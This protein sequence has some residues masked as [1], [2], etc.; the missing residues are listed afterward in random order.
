MAAEQSR[1]FGT[2]T[3]LVVPVE[4]LA[5]LLARFVPPG[6]AIDYL[7]IDCEGLDEAVLRGNDWARFRPAV[8]SVELHAMNLEHA[9]EHPA[10]RLLDGEGY[11]LRAHYFATS[12]FHHRSAM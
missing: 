7:N 3:R 4:T 6:V 10:V 5:V 8:I 12:V 9:A 2:P 1:H 11:V